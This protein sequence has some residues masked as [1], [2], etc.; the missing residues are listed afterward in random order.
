MKADARKANAPG[1]VCCVV[2][3]AALNAAQRARLHEAA[4]QAGLA[5]ESTG[6]GEQRM[7]TVGSGK[8]VVLTSDGPV[9]DLAVRGWLKQY[10][11]VTQSQ[12]HAAAKS[13]AQTST[14]PPT[15]ESF[16]A[17]TRRLIDV[18]RGA[19]VELG[20]AALAAGVEVAVARGICVRNLRV[21]DASPG[22]LG[23]TV[24]TLTLR[25]QADVPLPD[26]K[27]TVHDV[28][29]VRPSSGA[30][31]E[32]VARGIVCRLTDTKLSVAL[33]DA[34]EGGGLTDGA[35][36]VERLANDVTY[37][38]LRASLDAVQAAHAG[39][40]GAPP[41]GAHLVQLLFGRA[42]PRPIA[43]PKAPLKPINAS[44]DASQNAAVSFALAAPELALIWGPPGTGK[45]TALVELI[46]QSVARGE[47]VLACSA[48]N[49]AVD[50]LVER[51]RLASPKLRCVRL[52]HPARLAPA[53]VDACLDACVA[54]ADSSALAADI[55]KERRTLTSRLLKL[56]GS[57]DASERRDVRRQLGQLAKEERYR[58][59]QAVEE[60]LD[61]AQVVAA[62]LT[63][64][65]GKTLTQAG[66]TPRPPFDIVVIDEAAQALEVACWGPL[67]LGRKV[68]LAGD[69]MQLPPTV[70]SDEAA[71]GGLFTTLFERAHQMHAPLCRML[72]V[73]YRMNSAIA[74]WASGELYNHQLT[75]PASIAEHTLSDL[76]TQAGD[77][78][79]LLHIDTAG[80]DME[81]DA[82]STAGE[83]A[84]EAESKRNPGEAAVAM[85][86]VNRLLDAGL[87][88]S[89]IGVITPYSAQVQLLRQLRAEG[90]PRLSSVDISTVDGFQGREV[91][92][93]VISCVRSNADGNVGFLSDVR[94][95]NVAV[96]R[97]RRHCALIADSETLRSDAFLGRLCDWFE[98]HG[99]LMS[100]AQYSV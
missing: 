86:H 69:H 79:V 59:K 97:A 3:P 70:L 78:P 53:V 51:V 30:A 19:D 71:R 20:E 98:A 60:V 23:R 47:R 73:Q 99:D 95:M 74:D 15:V 48:S 54:R 57:R 83:M 9:S 17:T 43:P 28:V 11:G 25:G 5:H 55:A 80:C 75:A 7:I 87:Q 49:V 37:K 61:A 44:L 27:L 41:P 36:R 56:G 31:N 88:A 45:T 77:L 92:A 76:S 38:R 35:L 10:F 72:T 29:A 22:F 52:G 32:D 65:M 68:V 63:G 84:G 18:E 93:L 13:H 89:Q 33:D 14:A 50:N 6:E 2:F 1:S 67:L 12:S 62:T 46:L 26:H 21:V 40:G 91:E 90:G 16:V 34:P 24:L 58:Q 85:K 96:T 39:S 100:A 81:E 8:R 66:S 64:A 4:E 42:E 82:P 94:R